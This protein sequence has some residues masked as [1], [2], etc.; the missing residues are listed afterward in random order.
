MTEEKKS[1]EGFVA[2]LLV[3][4]IIGAALALFLGEKDREALRRN[5]K[6]KGRKALASLENAVGQEKISKVEKEAVKSKER[7]LKKTPPGRSLRS[8]FFTR[9]G[10]K[11]S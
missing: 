4:G 6:D 2:G 5:L 9:Q 11:L 10:K 1:G 8:R 3:G 7:K